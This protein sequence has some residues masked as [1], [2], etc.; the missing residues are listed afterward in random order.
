MLAYL[1]LAA[2][3]GWALHSTARVALR[4]CAQI[5]GVKLA[6]RETITEASNLAGSSKVRTPQERQ[7]AALFYRFAESRL[8]THRCS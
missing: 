7:S 4:N 2:G 8:A 3:T 5:E 1:T 6:L